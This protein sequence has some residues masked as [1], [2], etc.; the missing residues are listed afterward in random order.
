[1]TRSNGKPVPFFSCLQLLVMLVLL[2][3]ALWPPAA[4]AQAGGD[5]LDPYPLRAPD[6]SSP[7][8]TLRS[9]LDDVSQLI[10]A[11]HKAEGRFAPR[12]ARSY[13]RAVELVLLDEIT[14]ARISST[15]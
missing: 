4:D 1:M 5:D 15:L 14:A 11:Q 7:R 8:D 13:V 9:F 12:T 2:V 6:T 10:E 3:P